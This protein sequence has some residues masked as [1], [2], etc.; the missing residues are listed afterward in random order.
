MHFN[1]FDLRRS[2][3]R[4]SKTSDCIDIDKPFEFSVSVPERGA[5]GLDLRARSTERGKVQRGAIVK[6]FKPIEN[7]KVGYI[8]NECTQGNGSK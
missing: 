2:E 3:S 8:I 4:G 6:G 5:L 7:G 1:M